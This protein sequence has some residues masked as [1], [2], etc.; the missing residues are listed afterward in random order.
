MKNDY[1]GFKIIEKLET[2]KIGESKIEKITNYNYAQ[3]AQTCP[4]LPRSLTAPSP[5]P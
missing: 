1:I 4:A 3:C 5:S 2:P